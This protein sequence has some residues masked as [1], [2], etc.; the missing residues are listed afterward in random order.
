MYMT[1][2]ELTGESILVNITPKT[3]FFTEYSSNNVSI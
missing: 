3:M 1:T 2:Q